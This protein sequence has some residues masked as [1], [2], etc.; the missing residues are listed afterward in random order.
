MEILK[1]HIPEGLEFLFDDRPGKE[2]RCEADGQVHDLG[3]VQRLPR[4]A[5][6]R[7]SQRFRGVAQA[8]AGFAGGF[9]GVHEGHLGHD[10]ALAAAHGA[11]ALAVEGEILLLHLMGLGEGLADVPRNLHVGRR[12]G[13]Q[14]HADA[15][16]ADV[17]DVVRVRIGLP[18]ALHQ[19]ALAGTGDAGNDAADA[20][21]DIDRDA[22]QVVEGGVFQVE[23]SAPC[24][25]LN[26]RTGVRFEGDGLADHGA[27]G[28][29]A[30]KELFVR[31]LEHDPAAVD[32]RA[33]AHVH[34]MVGNPDHFRMVLHQQDRVAM[35]PKA[36][37]APFHPL[38]VPVVQAHAGLVQDIQDVGQRRIDV[39][40]DLASLGLTAGKRPHRTVQAQV[41][42][43]DLFE[44]RQ[45][46]ADGLFQVHGQRIRQPP[47]PGIEPGNGHRTGLGDVFPFDLAGQYLGVQPSSPA[48]GAGSHC[49]HRIQHRRVQKAL[50]RIDDAP[51]H[52]RDD[53][54]VLRRLGPARRRVLELD[55][56]T[57]QE[58]VQLFRRIVLD[59]LVQVEQ[60]APRIPDPPPA[61]LAEGDVMDRI[62]V[63]QALVKVHE[64]VDIQL[65]DLAESRT[66]GATPLRMVET[67]GVRIPYEGFSHTGEKQT[68]ERIDVGIGSHRGPGILRRLLLVDDHGDGQS[69]DLVHMRA[70]ILG[71]ILLHKGRER[72]VELPSG[73]GGD[74]VQHQRA[75]PGARNAGKN[76]DLVFGDV[77]G[78]VLEVVLPGTPDADRIC[79]HAFFFL[80]S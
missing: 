24:G 12:S 61:A 62:L 77:Q 31:A 45:P 43:T 60:A 3:D 55:L 26:D 25:S 7:I 28:R 63:V 47:D 5:R 70:S 74:G 44:R 30:P 13:P 8:A 49:Q 42:E 37:H 69:L 10:D 4:R 15:L 21:G 68:H 32:T 78:D 36:P 23:D 22:F 6:E 72:I 16:L 29:T 33:G 59:L 56:G 75:L 1:A 46:G 27:G 11:G 73:L 71:Q 20:E 79:R 52:P 66:A 35:V 41:S 51:V 38:D 14:A 58:Q 54:L 19:G 80:R 9:D 2:G 34:D 76:G 18:E 17:H 67:E 39:F 40:R 53:S 65:P 64:L 50:L 48:I 57:V